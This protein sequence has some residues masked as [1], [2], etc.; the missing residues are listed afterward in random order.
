MRVEDPLLIIFNRNIV[1]VKSDLKTS[2]VVMSAWIRR[3]RGSLAQRMEVSAWKSLQCDPVQ[4]F[5]LS[6]FWKVAI[7]FGLLCCLWSFTLNL[8]RWVI[9]V[10]APTGD[11]TVSGFPI[12][13]LSYTYFEWVNVMSIN[14]PI[15]WRDSFWVS[16]IR[17]RTWTITQEKDVPS[18]ITL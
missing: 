13:H 3:Y 6:S 16:S 5:L 10:P 12:Y 7:H 11:W 9:C 18:T 2:Y 14:W 4:D 1:R 8:C 15:P 17:T